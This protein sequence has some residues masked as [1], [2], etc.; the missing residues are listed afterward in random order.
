MDAR[1]LDII[2]GVSAFLVLVVLFA[3]FPMFIT[4]GIAYIAAIFVFILF[5]SGAG[6]M[7]NEK[8]S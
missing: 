7:V 4:G 6:Y 5:L 1:L 8:I 2:I 3:V